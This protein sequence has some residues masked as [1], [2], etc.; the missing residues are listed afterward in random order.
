[1]HIL[2]FS[3]YFPPEV[4]APA[5][6]TSEHAVE[7]VAQGH[8]VTVITCAPNAPEGKVYEGYRNTLFSREN[9]KGVNVYRVW[10]FMAPNKGF[11]LR[12]A[13]F[14]SY[15]LTAVFASL[16][17]KKVDVIVATSPQ[18]F[19]GW[20]GVISSYLKRKTF[21]LEIRDIWPESILTVGAMKKSVLITILEKLEIRMYNA[22]KHIIT[23]GEG[24]KGKIVE[25]GVSAE[26]ISVVINGVDLDKFA[27]NESHKFRTQFNAEN[28]WVCAYIGTLGMAHG[29]EV[30]LQAAQI[31]KE[32]GNTQVQF[33]LVGSGAHKNNLESRAR[34][35]NLDNVLFTGRLVKEDMPIILSEVDACLVHLKGTALFSTVIPSK[36]FECMA[37]NK[38]IIMGVKGES[39]SIVVEGRAGVAMEPDS[40]ESLIEC[41]NQIQK[42]PSDFKG[43]RPY[44][45]DNY[46]RKM[47]AN[48]MLG[49]LSKQIGV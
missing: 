20:A 41:V 33:W 8:K 36:I 10:S 3:H 47:L 14:L 28:K 38:P 43:G 45:T 21:V 7:W 37:L 6:R 11:I 5:S 40:A 35:M 30:V 49:V 2:F 19:C 13:N 22:A 29:L 42:S 16:F 48:K 12:I 31:L 23:V 26:K 17:I 1:M 32:S 9:Y 24:Y 4:N 46:Q 25:K 18:F 39:R 34:E 15:M 44:V 27:L